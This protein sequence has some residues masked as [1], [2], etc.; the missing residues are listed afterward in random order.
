MNVQ[1]KCQHSPHNF[2]TRL[3][4]FRDHTIL[5]FSRK[6]LSKR[7]SDTESWH[8]PTTKIFIGIS[9]FKIL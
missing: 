9:Y 4:I 7:E 3:G 5:F 6:L 8:H 2:E 1:N